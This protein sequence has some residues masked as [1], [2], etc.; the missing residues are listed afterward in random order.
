MISARLDGRL[1]QERMAEMNSH[2]ACCSGCFK[3][4]RLVQIMSTSFED[5]GELVP[6]LDFTAN[7]LARL[8]SLPAP[9]HHSRPSRILP[10]SIIALAAVVSLLLISLAGIS[11]WSVI[12]HPA[13]A[14]KAASAVLVFA[15]IASSIARALWSSLSL[16]GGHSVTLT[17]VSASVGLI[18]VALWARLV[19]QWWQLGVRA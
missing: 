12:Y 17:T 15:S 4:W 1:D 8:D 9:A 13:L 6:P 19:G 16:L 10:P 3:R 5:T 2:L 11:L 14:G 18:L 7:V